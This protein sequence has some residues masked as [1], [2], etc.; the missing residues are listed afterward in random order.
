MLKSILLR[1]SDHYYYDN[2][3]INYYYDNIG[4]RQ[5][6]RTFPKIM[7]QFEQ[8]DTNQVII[9]LTISNNLIH[10]ERERTNLFEQFDTE[11]YSNNLIHSLEL[12]LILVTVN[13][14]I[15]SK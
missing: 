2:I 5:R 8:F 13:R 4:I 14:S 12:S 7:T 1:Q 9:L 10:R 15:D 11:N 3:E 6:K